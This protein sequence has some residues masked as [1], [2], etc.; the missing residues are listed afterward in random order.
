MNMCQ[1]VVLGSLRTKPP[2]KG[3]KRLVFTVNGAESTGYIN[4]NSFEMDHRPKHER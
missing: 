3:E 4:K 2:K 1:V